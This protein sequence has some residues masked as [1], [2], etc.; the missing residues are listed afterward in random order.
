MGRFLNKRKTK[1]VRKKHFHKREIK[2]PLMK[3]RKT[4]GYFHL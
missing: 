4:T 1:V 3:A 2:T